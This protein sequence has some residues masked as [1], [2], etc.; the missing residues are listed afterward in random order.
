M[1]YIHRSLEERIKEYLQPNKVIIVLGARRVGKTE[2]IKH[3]L[4]DFEEKSLILNGEDQDVQLALQDRSVRNYKRLF[5]NT[6]LLIIDE[7]QAIPEIGLKL[8]LIVDSIDGI[9]VLVTGSSVFD[10]DNQL[11]EPLVGRSYTFKLFP[12]AQM[13]FSI[14][15]NYFDTIGNLGTR[16]IYGS[17]PELIHLESNER[18]ESYLKE[19]INSYLLKDILAFEGV[20]KRAKIVSLL[21]LIAFRVGSEISLES[22]GNDLDLNKS[23]V[24]R[25]LDLLSKVFI[26]YNLRGFSRNLDNEIT[27]KSKWYF[28][29]NGIRNALINNFNPLELRDD[30]GK[31]WENYIISER[32]KFQEYNK[33]YAANFFW[34]THTQQEIDW[35]EDRGGHL[36]A[37]EFK[38]SSAKKSKTPALWSKN[39]PDATYSTINPENYL[40]F[41]TPE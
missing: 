3:L 38:W 32:L 25:Y 11:G 40:Q 16:L 15:E 24:D 5:G 28:Y 29:D 10:L 30:H 1:E 12:L 27:K 23:T 20:R 41:I 36:H 6:S 4:S 33:L 13:E 26:I 31:L 2:L 9:K 34:R 19:Q 22:I 39:Y 7:A 37:Y 35:I 8:K 17:Y 18:K 21:R 14:K